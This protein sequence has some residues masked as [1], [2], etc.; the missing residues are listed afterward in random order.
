MKLANV[1]GVSATVAS[2]AL[3]GTCFAA[4]AMADS[5]SV[6][7][8]SADATADAAATAEPAAEAPEAGTATLD[9]ST[10]QTL[11]E[12]LA[13]LGV[14]SATIDQLVSA[15]YAQLLADADTQQIADT[16]EQAAQAYADELG[17]TA[18]SVDAAAAELS[19]A[20]TEGL[21]ELGIDDG[22]I[23]AAANE[24]ADAVSSAVSDFV[25]EVGS[26]LYDK[27]YLVDGYVAFSGDSALAS[28]ET[29]QT[30]GYSGFIFQLPADYTCAEMT[31]A[32]IQE[33]IESA[34]QGA[35]VDVNLSD[36]IEDGVVG[37]SADSKV[38]VFATQIKADQ[39]GDFNL[40]NFASAAYGLPC[41][42]Y[43]DEDGTFGA[44]GGASLDD[45][46]PIILT[47]AASTQDGTYDIVIAP[48]AG[49]DSLAML[50][51]YVEAGAPAEDLDQVSQ[52]LASLTG[53]GPVQTSGTMTIDGDA[54][55]EEVVEAAVE[56]A[57]GE[58]AEA[59][60]AEA[61]EATEAAPAEEAK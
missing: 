1:K 50:L 54:T 53:Y 43:T 37:V 25:G 36:L 4:P 19:Q 17:I 55:A 29:A 51:V 46:T 14:D 10:Q 9:A 61:A 5:A 41:F 12:I 38:A 45:G 26:Y 28:D 49:G 31:A 56:A 42:S 6:F 44:F 60:P 2:L 57:M 32:E 27:G 35:D 13:A 34:A 21:A 3:V 22:T 59:A 58:T 40:L 30:I 7:A 11:S 52:I 33:I 16:V 23:N 39:L 47:Q 48:S 20:V 18:E 15:D 24:L 8:S